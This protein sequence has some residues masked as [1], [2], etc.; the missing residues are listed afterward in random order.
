MLSRCPHCRSVIDAAKAIVH[1]SGTFLRCVV[2]GA[3]VVI[4][5]ATDHP[6][7]HRDWDRGPPP[8]RNV[9]IVSTAA[10]TTSSSGGP[11]WFV[12]TSSG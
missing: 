6:H 4:T 9:T 11:Q 3:W 7:D 10:S 8:T 12:P 5:P 2:C 1:H